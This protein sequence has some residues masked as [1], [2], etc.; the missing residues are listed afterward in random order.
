MDAP[1]GLQPHQLERL[2]EAKERLRPQPYRSARPGVSFVH[3][4]NTATRAL[5]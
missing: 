3:G 5:R 1:S 4:L 2:G